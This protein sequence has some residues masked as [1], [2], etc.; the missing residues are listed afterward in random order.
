VKLRLDV[1]EGLVEIGYQIFY[2]FD[3]DGEAD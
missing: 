3:A 2:V 1:R